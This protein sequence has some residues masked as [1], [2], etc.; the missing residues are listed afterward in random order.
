MGPERRPL[1]HGGSPA[2]ALRLAPGD[3]PPVRSR[4]E[5]R[6]TIVYRNAA[7]TGS[8]RADSRGEVTPLYGPHQD[9]STTPTGH[10]ALEPSVHP[11]K[12]RASAGVHDRTDE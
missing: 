8:P 12:A 1:A 7:R 11:R 5:K 2:R 3:I 10:S 9:G 6:R 4:A